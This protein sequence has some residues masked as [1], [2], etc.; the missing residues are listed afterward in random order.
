M[1]SVAK[2]TTRDYTSNDRAPCLA[3][4]D[5]N[6]PEFFAPSERNE[7]SNFLDHLPGPYLVIYS[8]SEGI[9]AAGGYYVTEQANLGALAWGL[10]TRAWHR[11]GVGGQLLQTRLSRLR[12]S[13]VDTVRVRTSPGSR[14]FFE[15]SG[16][17][18]VSVVPHGFAQSDLV[19]LHLPL[20][21]A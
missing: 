18:L 16:F 17:R 1:A 19:E 10:V 4:F 14:G 15:R 5:S 9:V 21:A 2:L 7:Y 3:L 8:P 20:R 6:V 11:R 12:A 13:G